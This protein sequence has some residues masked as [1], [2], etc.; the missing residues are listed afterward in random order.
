MV[1]SLHVYKGALGA[2]DAGLVGASAVDN[3]FRVLQVNLH[4]CKDANANLFSY[5]IKHSI[6]CIICQDPHV[7]RSRISSI[8]DKWSC[9][10]SN[11][12]NSA[13]IFTN[14][15][16][17]V[18]SAS[19]FNNSVF[20]NLSLKDATS[21]IIGSQYS[22]PSSDID[23]DCNEWSS[24]FPDFERILIGGDFNVHMKS[25]GYARENQRT[26]EFIEHLVTNNL[27]IINDP[28]SDYTWSVDDRHGRPDLTLGGA[29]ICG[30]IVSWLVDADECSFSDHKYIRYVLN[31]S[32]VRRLQTR[33]KTKNKNFYKFNRLF[34]RAIPVL[35]TAL[36]EVAS[37]EELENWME[38]FYEEIIGVTK[39]CFRRGTLAYSS[40]PSWYT[41]ELRSNRNRVNALYK[42]WSK[43]PD[44]IEYRETYRLARTQYKKMVRETKR[45]AWHDYCSKT[46][47]AYGSVFRYVTNKQLRHTDLVFTTLEESDA[48]DTYDDVVQM[49]LREHF[50]IDQVPDNVHSY[51]PSLPLGDDDDYNEFTVRELRY[52]LAQQHNNKAPGYDDLDA[53]IIKNLC[54]NYTDLILSL[55]NRCYRMGYFPNIWKKGLVVFFRKRNRDPSLVRSYRP[56]TLLPIFGKVY[57]RLIKMRI[58]TTLEHSGFLHVA[59]FGFREHR[60]TTHAML[61][62]QNIVREILQSNKYC[63]MVTLDI[64]GAFD[65]MPWHVLS[66]LIDELPID[67]FLK[68]VIK[69]YISL[70]KIGFRSSDGIRWFDT[71]LGCPQG[72]CLGP[73]LWLIVADKILKCYSAMDTSIVSYADDFVVFGGANT[74]RDLENK[75]NN[76]L[77]FMW[78]ICTEFELKLSPTKSEAMMFGRFTLESRH[79]IYKLDGISV[80]VRQNIK[81]LGFVLDSRFNWLDH[82]DAVREKVSSFTMNLKRTN[83]RDFGSP[84]SLRKTWYQSVIDKQITYGFVCWFPDLRIHAL[85]RLSSCQRIGLLSILNS[86]RS[87]STDALCVL[88]GVPPISIDLKYR[89]LKFEMLNR[90]KHIELD[91]I[92][93]RS[94]DISPKIKSWDFPYYYKLRNIKLLTAYE[95]SEHGHEEVTIYTDGSRMEEGTAC[96]FTVQHGGEFIYDEKLH[97]RKHNSIF[98]AELSA[99]R[100]AIDWFINS[101]YSSLSLKTDS[102]S[103]VRALERAFPDN[104]I[105]LQIFN[106][107]LSSPNKEVTVGWIRAHVGHI[108]NERAD[109]L[110]KEA[111]NP[112][113]ADRSLTIRYPRSIMNSYCRDQLVKAWQ[114]SWMVSDKGRETHRFV[115]KVNRDFVC[116]N[117]VTTY[118]LSGHG[119]FPQYL[120]KI[121]RR[122]TDKCDCGEVGSVT[123][124]LFGRCPEMPHFFTFYR[125]KSLRENAVR[126]LLKHDNYQKLCDIY[127]VLNEKY[128]F[129]KYKF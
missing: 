60:S 108:G 25:L 87:V 8:P 65:A 39:K 9:F 11:N 117:R 48:F 2:L 125:S 107:L 43:N 112:Q 98:Q 44:L 38:L 95:S 110:A 88:S 19:V 113:V 21:I 119:S 99:I 106:R 90:E 72:S 62:V 28:D 4:H 13:I 129:I 126:V 70:R 3:D 109:T 20:V 31:Y 18:I 89:F 93:I 30:S 81:Y 83:T 76:R 66:K 42:R 77:D 58:M 10:I 80:P 14:N 50:K 23:V 17:V 45:K 12:L 37:C 55:F 92:E 85:R 73:L 124:Y 61:K 78:S 127:N 114:Q 118:F 54:Y 104:E 69:S 120:F 29:D 52:V 94:S 105:T 97:M 49:L 15:D 122:N 46:A 16:Y 1:C 64:E 101:P 121:K 53:L 111:I 115:N 57:E 35:T 32:P 91:D 26:E 67:C 74:R 27:F 47:N 102:L 128:S 41:P 79:P 63:S 123:H 5:V 71:F 33:Y 7:F 59:Q 56:I 75:I 40:A 6:D 84:N 34:K 96:A 68:S 116:S 86:Y 22:P 103:S 82:L 100:G 24:A 51:T 36:T